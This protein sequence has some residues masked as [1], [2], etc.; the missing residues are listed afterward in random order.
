MIVWMGTNE[1]WIKSEVFIGTGPGITVIDGRLE[2]HTNI[3]RMDGILDEPKYDPG[4][5]IVWDERRGSVESG[6]A[7]WPT[8]H[9]L[10]SAA[11]EET[12]KVQMWYPTGCLKVWGE[13]FG[14]GPRVSVPGIRVNGAGPWMRVVWQCQ[15]CDALLDESYPER[16]VEG[17]T[18]P[19]G[20][21][22]IECGGGMERMAVGPGHDPEEGC[23]V[24]LVWDECFGLRGNVRKLKVNLEVTRLDGCLVVRDE[25]EGLR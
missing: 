15:E 6:I 12:G 14:L 13:R 10:G 9:F 25:M 1:Q 23:D 5:L 19:I 8:W 4:G 18:R 21:T 16:H 17:Y 2:T 11:A 20:D 24:L 7:D 3:G 22:C